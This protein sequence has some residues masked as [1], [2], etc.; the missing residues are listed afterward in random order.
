M[1]V[2]AGTHF[3]MKEPA[4]QPALPSASSQPL[5]CV[6]NAPSP[7]V[8]VCVHILYITYHHILYHYTLHHCHYPRPHSHWHPLYPIPRTPYP[9]PRTP[10]LH[11]W[12]RQRHHSDLI[13]AAAATVHL[14]LYKP[15][16]NGA[17]IN[18]HRQCLSD[19]NELDMMVNLVKYS[20]Q[21]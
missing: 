19:G 6:L 13:K 4:S 17:A 8:R 2:V 21:I 20:V 7:S 9:V 11:R 10:A 5:M 18:K 14:F 3:S 16:I 1:R 15:P 12:Q